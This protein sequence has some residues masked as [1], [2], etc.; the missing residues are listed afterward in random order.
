[1]LMSEV[2][3]PIC[4]VDNSFTIKAL[5]LTP[6]QAYLL[7]CSLKTAWMR[8]RTIFAADMQSAHVQKK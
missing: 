4:M 1:M 2:C 6:K 5:E 7:L 3:F 8:L